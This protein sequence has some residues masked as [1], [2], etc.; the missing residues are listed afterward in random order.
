MVYKAYDRASG[1]QIWPT[2]STG[3]ADLS[4]E[5]PAYA[6]ARYDLTTSLP[7]STWHP[8]SSYRYATPSESPNFN[9]VS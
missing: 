6:A 7:D 9:Y 1:K 2:T 5:E 8:G 3:Y 4:E